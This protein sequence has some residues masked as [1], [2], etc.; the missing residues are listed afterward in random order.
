MIWKNFLLA[1]T[2]YATFTG[3]SRRQEYWSFFLVTILFGAAASV[4]D[5]ILFDNEVFARMLDAFFFIPSL[6][7]G[8]R[9]LHDTGRS[10]WWQLIALTGIGYIVLLV[11]WAQDSHYDRNKWG[12]SPKYSIRDIEIEDEPTSFSDEQIV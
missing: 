8:A 1:F 2:K 5:N 3:R 11:W 10:G 4:W 7:V 6:A 9:R 12:D